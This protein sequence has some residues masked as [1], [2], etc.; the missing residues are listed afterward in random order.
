MRRSY[1]FQP[2]RDELISTDPIRWR[3]QGN[4]LDPHGPPPVKVK[5]VLSASPDCR[6][7][8][9]VVVNGRVERPANDPCDVIGTERIELSN[10]TMCFGWP[11]T[12]IDGPDG[13]EI[14]AD[15]DR[16]RA[17]LETTA[18]EQRAV[19]FAGQTE[20]RRCSPTIAWATR[21]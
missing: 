4:T 20:P 12:V 6:G 10:G 17:A 5:A 18:K 7:V 21:Q 11:T 1:R 14:V 2:G 3:D 16:L 19:V 8:R 9:L 13:R 15:P